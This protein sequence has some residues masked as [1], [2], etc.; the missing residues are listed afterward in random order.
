MPGILSIPRGIP[1]TSQRPF[2]V[3]YTYPG[4]LRAS[5][6]ESQGMDLTARVGGKERNLLKGTKNSSIPKKS[7]S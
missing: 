4:I 1:H 6:K 2:E 7:Q 3:G 5:V